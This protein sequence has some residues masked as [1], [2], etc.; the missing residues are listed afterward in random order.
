ME[1]RPVNDGKFLAGDDGLIY[2]KLEDGSVVPM[3][4]YYAGQKR[5]HSY[6]STYGKNGSQLINVSHLIAEAF[7][8]K[9]DG[10]VRLIHLDGDGK[11]TAPSNLRWATIPEYKK[12]IQSFYKEVPCPICGKPRRDSGNLGEI[13]MD[14]MATKR[15]IDSI[16]NTI[17]RR[18]S[19]YADIPEIE[20]DHR[21]LDFLPYL[22]QGFTLLEV[23]NIFGCSRQNVSCAVD[24]YV[25]YLKKEG[26]MA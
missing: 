1:L 21:A 26:L 17:D 25:H 8:E 2:K 16:A 6:I 24:T 13:C 5:S 23:A 4:I 22:K 7:L 18:A 12:H 19:Y 9:P 20:G 14:C 11:N 15:R 3:K 10:T